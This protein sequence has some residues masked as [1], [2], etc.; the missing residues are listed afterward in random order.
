[1]ERC[2]P[3]DL[4]LSFSQSLED[5]ER[6]HFTSCNVE[7]R[8]FVVLVKYANHSA[9]LYYRADHYHRTT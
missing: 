2:W 8:R 1:M 3:V 6:V 9:T 7:Q 4:R 5:R